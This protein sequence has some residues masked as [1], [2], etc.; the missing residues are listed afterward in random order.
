MQHPM[1]NMKMNNQKRKKLKNNSGKRNKIKPDGSFGPKDLF[2]DCPICQ[3][4]KNA[5]R[6]G[7]PL[8]M[9]ELKDAFK[10]AKEKGAI[11][12]GDMFEKE[13]F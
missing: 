13:E 2:D 9:S 10:Q 4:E 6:R 1:F 5:M 8:T 12:G 11:V 3:A 7:K